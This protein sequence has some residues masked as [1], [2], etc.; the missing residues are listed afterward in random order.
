[1]LFSSSPVPWE[2]SSFLVAQPV[3]KY[4]VSSAISTHALSHRRESQIDIAPNDAAA[5]KS[6]V[7]PDRQIHTFGVC[8]L[9]FPARANDPWTFPIFAECSYVEI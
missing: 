8:D 2:F 7:S 6:G 4:L 9:T 5:S 1:M 3:C